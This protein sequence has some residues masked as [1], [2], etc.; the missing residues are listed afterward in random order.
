[1]SYSVANQ[2]F[3]SKLLFFY[4]MQYFFKL[5]KFDLIL[6]SNVSPSSE[7]MEELWVVCGFSHSTNFFSSNLLISF[8]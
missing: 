1:M 4:L 5:I 6:F 7:R 8:Y 2:S 3:D